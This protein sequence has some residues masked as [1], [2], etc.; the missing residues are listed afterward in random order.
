MSEKVFFATV[1][2]IISIILVLII[3]LT[4]SYF[5][6]FYIYGYKQKKNGFI[7]ENIVNEKLK[8]LIKGT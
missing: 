5:L 4:V 7:F 6:W 3:A 8:R 2:S 1:I